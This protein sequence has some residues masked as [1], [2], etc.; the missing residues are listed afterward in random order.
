MITDYVSQHS[1]LKISL[2]YIDV[3][4]YESTKALMDY[5]YLRVASGLLF[6]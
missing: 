4:V 6:L 1:E 3:D 5:L 2:L